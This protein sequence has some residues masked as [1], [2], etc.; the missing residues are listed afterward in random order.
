[1]LDS[2]NMSQEGESTLGIGLQLKY[3]RE[4]KKISV[5][6]MAAKLKLTKSVID[7]LEV[8]AWDKL[9]GR[10]YARG[11]LTSYAN[12]L[13]LSTDDLLA[14]FDAGYQEELQPLKVH[15]NHVKKRGFPWFKF[16]LLVLAGFIVW[17]VVQQWPGIKT[18]FMTQIGSE[19][20]I[21]LVEEGAEPATTPEI[22]TTEDGQ[23]SIVELA[24]P[25]QIGNDQITTLTL[26]TLAAETA[27]VDEPIPVAGENS[28]V[29]LVTPPTDPMLATLALSFGDACWVQ[30]KDA[31]GKTLMNANK[32]LGETVVL[33][34]KS[35]LQLVLGDASKV[36]V[37]FNGTLFDTKPFTGEG[38]V[39]RFS[40]KNKQL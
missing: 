30:V 20:G 19:E 16:V 7:N 38:G 26:P 39:A 3:A 37:R 4:A 13:D 1:M 5:S 9:N 36:K 24:A 12:F 18:K 27:A 10:T 32:K 17:F 34:G 28:E 6:E 15:R 33:T 31:D 40:L 8:D 25:E 21:S 11:Y 2:E 29:T 35:P 23:T 22:I 14:Q